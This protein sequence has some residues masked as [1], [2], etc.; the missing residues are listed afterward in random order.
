MRLTVYPGSPL[1]G[2]ITLPGDKSL[3][4]RAAIIGAMANGESRV[5]NFLVAGVTR[6]ML[7]ALTA[8]GVGWELEGTTLTIQAGGLSAWQA[9][10][11]AIDC[12]N[13]ATTMR[14]LA[15]GLAAAGLPAVLDGSPRLR[16]RPMNRIVD[17]LSRMGVPVRAEDGR[18]PLMFSHRKGQLKP[19]QYTLPVASAQVKSCLLLAGLSA[20]GSTMLTEPGP[21]RDHTERMLRSLGVTVVSEARNGSHTQIK[22]GLEKSGKDSISKPQAGGELSLNRNLRYTTHLVPPHQYTLPPMRFALPGDISSAAFLIVAALI[23]PGS[24]VWLREILLNP[25]RTGLLDALLA[26]GA[27]VRVSAT[28]ERQGEPLGDIFVRASPLR[29][30]HISGSMVVRMIDEFP[31]FAVAA[32]CAQGQTV[33]SEALELRHKESDRI[34]ALCTELQRLGVAAQETPE[35]F[36]ITGGGFPRGG[37]VDSHGDHRLAM[38]LAVA[39]LACLQAVTV[40]EAEIVSESFPN[41]SEV[42]QSLGAQVQVAHE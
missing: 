19:L 30:T 24:Q 29:A 25:T 18:A 3:S 4:H 31:A 33:V 23:T 6:A 14:L 27:D 12:G 39:G 26:M 7:N 15:G 21:S 42:L 37:V 36:T 5:E 20:S 34:S 17:P 28:G 41:F 38:A 9:P 35:G 11:A 13:S 1:R 16:R 40:S 2:E 32:A 10:S 8:L 22:P